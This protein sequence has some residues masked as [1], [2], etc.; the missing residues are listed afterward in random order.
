MAAGARTKFRKWDRYGNRNNV[1]GQGCDMHDATEIWLY[2]LPDDIRYGIE[3]V[4]ILYTGSV[5]GRT[6]KKVKDA[7]FLG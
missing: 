3:P 2:G 5:Y 7:L 6:L 1:R 4:S